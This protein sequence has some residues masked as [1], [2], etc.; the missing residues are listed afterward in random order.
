M[1]FEW[2]EKKNTANLEKHGI[3]FEDATLVFDDINALER[4][5]GTYDGEN[6]LKIIG[7]I[8]NILVVLVIFVERGEIIRIISAR[9]ATRQ[10]S[11]EYYNGQ[12]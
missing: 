1:C 6:R 3:S 7:K 5:D 11:E 4:V 10:E 12:N 2:D 9:K 8:Y